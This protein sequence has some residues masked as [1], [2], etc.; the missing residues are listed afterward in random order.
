MSIKPPTLA[1]AMTPFPYSVEQGASLDEATRL[2]E[3]HNVRHLPVTRDHNV[4]GLITERD[5]RSMLLG[6]AGADLE[7]FGVAD[8]YRADAY[9][10]D[11]HEPLDNVLHT[12]AEGHISAA[13]VTKAG[14]LA[15]VFTFVD[16]CR[17]YAEFLREHF[18]PDEGDGGDAA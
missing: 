6:R 5:I 16:A 15:G 3:E 4:V 8:V 11:L 2:M 7:A 18:A 1:T 12:M 14:R 9:V 17:S 10:V 13:V